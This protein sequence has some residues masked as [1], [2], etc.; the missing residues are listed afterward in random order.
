MVSEYHSRAIRL[1]PLAA[2]AATVL[3]AAMALVSTSAADKRVPDTSYTAIGNAIPA[4]LT[5][6]SGDPM[7]GKALA[8]STA[9]GNCAL[10]HELP[11]REVAVFGTMGP[12][13]ANVGSRL[14][15]GVLRLRIVDGRRINPRSAMPSY[16]RVQSLNRVMAQY[17]GRPILDAQQVEDIVAYLQTLKVP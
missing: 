15:A 6:K 5:S 17:R 8:L 9:A 4:P 3:G 2:V 16:Y 12:S 10:C 1:S 11:A 13:L 7:R 14:D